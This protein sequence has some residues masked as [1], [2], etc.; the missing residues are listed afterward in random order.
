MA[1][2]LASVGLEKYAEVFARQEIDFDLLPDLTSD[3]LKEMGISLGDRKRLLQAIGRRSMSTTATR[4]TATEVSVFATGESG[5]ERRQITITFCDL[6]GYTELSGRLDPEELADVVRAYQSS[7]SQVIERWEG[8]IAKFLG[9][10]V[11]AYFGWP[12]AHED[13]AERAVRAGLE[14]CATVARQRAGD[15]TVLAARVGV[16]TGLVMVGELIG[17]GVAQQE[18]VVGATPNLAAR[19][20]SIATPGHV[21]IAPSTR[22]L[23]GDL[24]ELTNLGKFEIKGF[25]EPLSIHQVDRAAE[26]SSRFEARIGR[27]LTP[28]V[29]RADELETLHRC[30][31]DAVARRGSTVLITGEAGI[32]KSRLASALI[33]YAGTQPHVVLKDQCSPYHSNTALHPVIEQFTRQAKITRD[34]SDDVRL[35]K[36]VQMLRDTVGDDAETIAI[37][38]TLLSIPF[39]HRFPA[40]TLGALRQRERTMEIVNQFALGI[41]RTA[42]LLLVIEDAH[43]ADPTTLDALERHVTLVPHEQILA[44]VTAR[45]GFAPAW[46]GWAH[47]TVV[48]LSRVPNAAAHDI[49]ARVAGAKTVPAA[50]A[51][52]IVGTADGVP[53]FVEEL[54][55]T[56]IES[57]QLVDRG[58][59]YELT[60]SAVDLAI[61]ATLRDSLAARVDRL[62]QDKELAQVASAIGRSFPPA[63]LARVVEMDAARLER[64][65]SLLVEAGVVDAQGPATERR[66]SFR[67]ALIQEVAYRS[68]LKASRRKIH[69]RIAAALEE[70]FPAEVQAHPETL[71]LHLAEAGLNERAAEQFLM[72]ARRALRV[73][74][75]SEALAHLTRGLDL[76]RGLPSGPRRDLV[77]LRLHATSGTTWMLARGW[78]TPEVATAY[79]AATELSHAASNAAEAVW[80]LWGAWVHS[81]VRGRINEAQGLSDRISAVAR[82]SGDPEAALIAEMIAFQVAHYAGRLVESGDRERAFQAS[83]RPDRHRALIHQYSTDL[84]LV[85]EVHRA[86]GLWILGRADDALALARRA[87]S[88]ARSLEHP[89]SISWCL[90]WGALPYLLDGQLDELEP[91][92]AEGVAI[93][94]SQGF[95][96]TEAL[97]T[98]LSGWLDG[99]R[100]DVVGGLA[101][102]DAGLAAFTATGAEIAVPFF[103]TLEAG[104][105]RRVDR[106]ADALDVLSRAQDQV[107]RWGERWQESEIHRERGEVLMRLHDFAGARESLRRAGDVAAE[108]H[109]PT[110]QRHAATSLA[111]LHELESRAGRDHDLHRTST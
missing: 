109:A 108:Q 59:R 48:D 61:P 33:D 89:Y 107:E 56:V 92:L 32:G 106:C 8:Y 101:R 10:G 70:S 67:H 39:T 93:A 7:C 60:R 71:G 73:S 58:D 88:L 22:D 45:P 5:V 57:G 95:A 52:R 110:W 44:V 51:A 104:L 20:Q 78:A 55:R 83:F 74:A 46:R 77:A 97:G 31:D 72:A 103:L 28:F 105:L 37:M 26:S 87:E 29:G 69:E 41:S 68:L 54:T 14:L 15:G 36:L 85:G 66:F 82:Q 11:L 19:L 102:M 42:P 18:A 64:R 23:L 62:G 76:V 34:D 47:V 53:L 1:Q 30:W 21:A 86:I 49:V 91:R 4:R 90:T 16:A 43:W 75:P 80:I 40:L 12:R 50:V 100:G 9:D 35:D 111:R 96:Y 81:H 65:L 6:V 17:E 84:Q 98:V 79:K 13:D 63:L 94:A 99:E 3:D 27:G 25:S 24:F 2:W 38:A